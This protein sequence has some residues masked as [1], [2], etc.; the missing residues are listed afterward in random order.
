MRKLI[1]IIKKK[2]IRDG[3]LTIALVL[4]LVAIFILIN[5]LFNNLNIT[6]LDFTKEKLYTLSD[7]SKEQISQVTQN[8]TIYFFGYDEESTTVTLAKQYHDVNDKITIQIIDT[9]ER[10]DLAAQYNV[11]TTS[12]LVAVQATERY[13]II[14]SSEMYTYDS[15]TYQT[16]DITEQK[17]T[18][19][20]L[21]VTIAQKPQIYFLTGHGE[22][23]IDSSS[24]MGTLAT[25]IE[26]D[27]NDVN[28][29]DL[30]TSDMPET[31]D[32]LVIANPTSDFTDLETEK[33]QN[34]INAG[35]KIVW[36]QDPYVF[37]SNWTEETT[38]PNI[39]KILSQFGISFSSGVI[40]EESTE[41]MIAGTPDLIIPQMTY[42]GIVKDLYTDGTIALL[43]SGKI[44]TVSDEELEALGVTASP[45][46]Q[47]TES[48]FYREDINSDISQKLDSDEEGPFVLAEILTKKIDDDTESTLVAYSN[49]LFATNYTVHI[50]GSI[51]TP[52]S[53]RENKDIILNTI[54][55]LSDREDSIR[56]RKDTGLVSFE[57]ITEKEN[58]IVLWIIF[59][60]PII[61]IIAGIVISIVRKRKK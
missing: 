20:I 31:C 55:Y 33:I 14:D 4:I 48:S 46:L 52:I 42:N 60:I 1:E 35:G 56:I 38:Y 53:I 7:E 18:N 23:G 17:L 10:P 27:V 11:S 41:N 8:V 49:A 24:P 32:V 45:F 30:L 59:T 29:I 40:C 54:A 61:I 2:W 13:K 28:T 6:P 26:N 12:Q 50:S 19:A 16:I 43:D 37:T 34:Y 36:M 15:S 25:Y 44:N 9:S 22:Y 51:G 57:A 58:R 5:L 39:T 3:I 21:D 47:S